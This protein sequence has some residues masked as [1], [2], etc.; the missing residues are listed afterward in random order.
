MSRHFRRAHGGVTI[1]LGDKHRATRSRG[2]EGRDSRVSMYGMPAPLRLDLR[3]L[4]NDNSCKCPSMA[5]PERCDE[6]AGCRWLKRLAGLKAKR[7]AEPTKGQCGP[8]IEA[9]AA[10]EDEHGSMAA[11]RA[12]EWAALWPAVAKACITQSP[13]M[14]RAELLRLRGAPP[15]QAGPALREG[16]PT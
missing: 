5:H 4:M 12:D 1:R 15:G 16:E 11:V 13:R 2:R 3:L 10:W 7:A 9:L 8:L 14:L 6:G